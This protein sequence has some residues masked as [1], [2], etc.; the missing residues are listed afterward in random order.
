[1]RSLLACCATIAMLLG[2]V[3]CDGDAGTDT[4]SGTGEDDIKVKDDSF[5][6]FVGKW[7]STTEQVAPK[8]DLPFN[9]NI[10]R[11]EFTTERDDSDRHERRRMIMVVRPGCDTCVDETIPKGTYR[12]EATP[13]TDQKKGKVFTTE[14]GNTSSRDFYEFDG[15]LLRLS[16]TIGGEKVVREFKRDR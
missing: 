6:M 5:K 7:K 11:L 12:S 14:G 8:G 1:M 16:T 13:A 3:A 4:P 2:S 15:D 9:H 10:R